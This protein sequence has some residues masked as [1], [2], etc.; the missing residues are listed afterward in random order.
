MN[1]T[2]ECVDCR[3]EFSYDHRKGPTRQRCDE[4][5]AA[6]KKDTDKEKTKRWREAHPERNR[7]QQNRANRKRLADPA[8]RQWKRDNEL[9]RVY[10]IT[11]A[12]LDAMLEE[13]NNLCAI[14]GN[15]HVG[16]GTRLHIDHCH[17][18][19]KVRG[20]LCGNCNTA[21]GLLGDDPERAEALAAY[22]RR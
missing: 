10:G 13:Q 1:K 2:L 5:T 9:R 11:R 7:D 19:K 12:E 20:L 22:L 3:V 14:C 4:C 6:R 16:V 15:G 21:I 8:F 18:S 17:N